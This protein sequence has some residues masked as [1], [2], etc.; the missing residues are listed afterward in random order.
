MCKGACHSLG[1]NLSEPIA[2]KI[3]FNSVCIAKWFEGKGRSS[4][5]GIMHNGEIDLVILNKSIKFKF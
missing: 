3:K 5:L 4:I 1:Q 2:Y